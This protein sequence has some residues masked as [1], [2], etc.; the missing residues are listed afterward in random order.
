MEILEQ[1]KK[2]GNRKLGK[3]ESR[4][5]WSNIDGLELKFK[6]KKEVSSILGTAPPKYVRG[7][8]GLGGGGSMYAHKNLAAA[9]L[10]NSNIYR[11]S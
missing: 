7:K 5:N 11:D 1:I 9:R 2:E 3:K 4:S 8:E 6:D 10:E